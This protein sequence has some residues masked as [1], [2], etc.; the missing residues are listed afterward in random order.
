MAMHF[1]DDNF[2]AEVLDSEGLVLVD[3]WAQWCTPCLMLG[4]TI[5]E[6]A[7]DFKG[8]VKVGKLNVDENQQITQKYGIMSIPTVYLFKG[9]QIVKQFVG[10]QPKQAFEAALKELVN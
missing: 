5:E 7:K 6:L 9:G 3:F 1:T 10:V 2:Q 8:K 4:P